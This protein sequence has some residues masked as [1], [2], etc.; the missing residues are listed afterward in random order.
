MAPP[1][2]TKPEPSAAYMS[3]S[4]QARGIVVVAPLLGSIA[5]T[6]VDVIH[7][8]RPSGPQATE[9]SANLHRLLG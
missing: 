4:G 1:T 5:V 3:P 8:K 7:A 2:C 9:R 6:A